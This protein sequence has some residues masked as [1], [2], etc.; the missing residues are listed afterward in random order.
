[1]ESGVKE[2]KCA[3]S[4]SGLCFFFSLNR[5]SP[6]TPSS[7]THPFFIKIK[8]FKISTLDWARAEK[9]SQLFCEDLR[10]R[11]PS[12]STRWRW[13]A[14]FCPPA[15]ARRTSDS[16]H[17]IWHDPSRLGFCEMRVVHLLTLLSAY[18]GGCLNLC[19]AV[20]L[21]TSDRTVR[22]ASRMV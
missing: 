5:V 11:D 3:G 4:R 20:R 7:M 10:W 13:E 16:R 12:P 15:Q 21:T 19:E 9:Y 8:F 6:G 14:T 2:K 18:F 1:M 17:W 22:G